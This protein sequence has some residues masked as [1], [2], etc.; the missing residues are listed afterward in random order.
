[1]TYQ[2][3]VRNL[4]RGWTMTATHGVDEDLDDP[5]LGAV[6][7]TPFRIRWGF[8][9]DLIPGPLDPPRVTLSMW[10]RSLATEPP[11]D[12][13]DVISVDVR[14][15]PT[16]PY[17]YR[18]EGGRVTE[19]PTDLVP[20]DPWSVRTTIEVTDFLADAASKFPAAS[21]GW[22]DVDRWQ[23]RFALLGVKMA[24]SIG[25]PTALATITRVP[26]ELRKQW[27]GESGANMLRRLINSWAPDFIHHSVV[28]RHTPGS[29]A[30][31]TGYV[32]AEPSDR[33][34]P[35]GGGIPYSSLQ[36]DPATETRYLVVPAARRE[37]APYAAPLQF[38]VVG[39]MV[40]VVSIP[41]GT[42]PSRHPAL[43]AAW[44]RIPTTITRRRDHV[45]NTSRLKGYNEST[46]AYGTPNYAK[47]ATLETANPA[48]VVVRGNLAREVD[49]DLV[50]QQYATDDTILSPVKPEAVA[51]AN[52]YLSDAETLRANRAYSGLLLDASLMTDVEAAAVLPY[53]VPTPPG[54]LDGRIVR[55]LS[56]WGVEGRVTSADVIPGGFITSGQMSIENGRLQYALATSPGRPIYLSTAPTPITLGAFIAKTFATNPAYTPATL[57]PTVTVGDLDQIGA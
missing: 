3:T 57:N 5:N 7:T 25:L 26:P 37:P 39:S 46:A 31:P 19:A 2:V 15:G 1:M 13:G 50:F 51:Q 11:V 43:S 4:T 17:L 24:R 54:I 56:V 42:S 29:T 47:S 28:S 34:A 8:A 33:P 14:L 45:I 32:W 48:D 36:V 23:T 10:S 22:G 6:L 21:N 27:Y 41:G 9:D 35:G 30:Y 18:F 20:T 38:A 52:S 44:C 53:L 12:L 16:G 40:T 49:T 55:H